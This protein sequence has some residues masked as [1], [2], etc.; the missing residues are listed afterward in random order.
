MCLNA[1]DNIGLGFVSSFAPPTWVVLPDT[2]PDTPYSIQ[3]GSFAMS[4]PTQ[5]YPSS[6]HFYKVK[7]VLWHRLLHTLK[8]VLEKFCHSLSN[9]Q[10]E[11]GTRRKKGQLVAG[12]EPT[13][14]GYWLAGSL[15]NHCATTTGAFNASAAI[16]FQPSQLS[17]PAASQTGSLTQKRNLEGW[18]KMSTGCRT[19]FCRPK[20][21]FVD[22]NR[23][24]ST[25]TVVD[26][27]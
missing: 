8:I 9:G 12:F 7:S 15:F 13:A 16:F 1:H 11:K 24:L 21:F 20:P 6:L 27:G 23:F 25:K 5:S 18:K 22:Q 19:V 14:H 4:E 26:R 3:L 10:S 17:L 2:A